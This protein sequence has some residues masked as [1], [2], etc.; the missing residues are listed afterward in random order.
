MRD[1]GVPLPAVAGGSRVHIHVKEAFR[2]EAQVDAPQIDERADEQPRSYQEHQ[3]Q[4]YLA[5]NQEPAHRT[6]TGARLR[7]QQC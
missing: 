3:R 1:G 6:S 5:D 7:V 4:R 2:R